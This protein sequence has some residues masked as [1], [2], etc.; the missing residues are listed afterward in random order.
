[1]KKLFLLTVL[2][3]IG[4]AVYRQMEG[5]RLESDLWTEATMPVDL[6]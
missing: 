5:Q 3:G 2:A 6:R 1:M 4:Y